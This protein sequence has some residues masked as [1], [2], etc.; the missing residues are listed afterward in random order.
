MNSQGGI[1]VRNFL[2]VPGEVTR[3]LQIYL[4]KN[5]LDGRIG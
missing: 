1:P 5:V 3:M 4:L 2:P